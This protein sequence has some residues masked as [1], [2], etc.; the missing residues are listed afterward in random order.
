MA[1]TRKTREERIQE[2]LA[3]TQ[4]AFRKRISLTRWKIS[5]HIQ[6]YQ[7]VVYTTIMRIKTDSYGYDAPGQYVLYAI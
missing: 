6:N 2:I 4:K 1:K 7:K 3:G 5:L